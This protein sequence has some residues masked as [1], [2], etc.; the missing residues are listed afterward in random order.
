MKLGATRVIPP[1]SRRSL[2]S[3]TPKNGTSTDI[4]LCTGSAYVAKVRSPEGIP[5]LIPMA[6]TAPTARV[7]TRSHAALVS[8]SPAVTPQP[9]SRA[10]NL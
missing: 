1:L 9:L 7:A 5:E 3:R 10:V 4:R 8:R 2:A 6:A